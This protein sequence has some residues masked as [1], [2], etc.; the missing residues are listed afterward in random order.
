M[1]A[2]I[3]LF[4]AIALGHGGGLPPTP[5]PRQT[6]FQNFF[7]KNLYKFFSY[8]STIQQNESVLDVEFYDGHFGRIK[9]FLSSLL[10]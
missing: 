1:T 6:I 10:H 8:S 7:V 2:V 5:P 3:Y 9:K 4:I